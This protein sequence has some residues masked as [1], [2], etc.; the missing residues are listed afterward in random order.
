MII[1]FAHQKGGV[2]KSTLAFNTAVELSKEYKVIV[3]DLERVFKNLCQPD[4]I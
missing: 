1:T 3:I 2:G 4:I